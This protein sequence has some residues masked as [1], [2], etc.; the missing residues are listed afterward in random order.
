MFVSS[1]DCA[2]DEVADTAIAVCEGIV[3]LSVSPFSCGLS[4]QYCQPCR[5][6]TRPDQATANFWPGGLDSANVTMKRPLL[7]CKPLV[8]FRAVGSRVQGLDLKGSGTT[9]A[10]PP[11]T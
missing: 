10:H 4:L 8:G 5:C 1:L 6:E 2:G 7:S 3:T 9:S 11:K